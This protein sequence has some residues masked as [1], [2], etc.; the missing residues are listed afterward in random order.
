[1]KQFIKKNLGVMAM[2]VALFVSSSVMAQPQGNGPKIPD[3]KEITKMVTKLSE[4]LTLTKDQETSITKMYTTHFDQ[5]KEAT[6]SGRPDRTKMEAL[7]T[8]LEKSVNSVLTEDQQKL[9]AEYQKKN[10]PQRPEGG[11]R[12]TR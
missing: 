10:A 9:F 6:K 5:V 8:E 2:I 4:E 3:A 7:K 1:M 12:P 11:Q